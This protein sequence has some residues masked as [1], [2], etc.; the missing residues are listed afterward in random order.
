MKSRKADVGGKSLLQKTQRKKEV[1]KS[2][3]RTPA[4]FPQLII[5]TAT[6]WPR[7]DNMFHQSSCFERIKYMQKGAT[8]L[9]KNSNNYDACRVSDKE[10]WCKVLPTKAI[11]TI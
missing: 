4:K 10:I 3:K 9:R 5:H 1:K 11:F 8:T 7:F 2:A 6:Y